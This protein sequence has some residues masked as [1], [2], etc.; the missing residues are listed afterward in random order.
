MPLINGTPQG[1][2]PVT[3]GS[4]TASA[5]TIVADVVDYSSIALMVNGTFSASNVTFEGSLDGS[6]W[7]P[8]ALARTATN[9]VESTSGS[10]SAA[11]GY[12]W[13]G[14]VA[15]VRYF[16]VRSTAHTSGTANWVISPSYCAVEPAPAI[17]TPAVTQSGT[18]TVTATTP[19]GTPY[20]AT[21]TASTNAASVKSSAGNLFELSV[22]NPTATG[23]FVKIYNKASAPTVG[24]DIPVLTIPAAAGTTVVHQFGQNGKRFGTGIAIAATAAAAATDTASAVAGVQIHGTYV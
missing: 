3:T 5:Q 23:T 11:P 18:W 9:T 22:S 16:R 19:T 24:T 10:L 17:G 14:S 1:A 20:S 21:T 2:G 8:I 15:A 6:S 13:E 12:A 7:F 4:I